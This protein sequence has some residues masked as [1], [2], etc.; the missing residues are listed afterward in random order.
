MVFDPGDGTTKD[1]GA[2][3][4]VQRLE[5]DCRL[6][7]KVPGL[8]R[9]S[10]ERRSRHVNHVEVP[11]GVM[12]HESRVVWEEYGGTGSTTGVRKAGSGATA[13]VGSV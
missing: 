1:T 9:R 8:A 10:S 6:R 5:V 3:C 12:V 11:V 4:Q 13:G 7:G 2:Y